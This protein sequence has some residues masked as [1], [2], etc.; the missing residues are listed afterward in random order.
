MTRRSAFLV[1]LAIATVGQSA[2][3]LTY[4]TIGRAG[5]R[6]GAPDL[7]PAVVSF[8]RI[9]LFPGSTIP[10]RLLSKVPSG[11]AISTIFVVNI[12]A[13]SIAVLVVLSV[14]RAYN[15]MR[16]RPNADAPA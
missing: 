3:A 14:V 10:A 6:T 13:W 15:R 9:A 11:L 2:V 16:G 12:A 5:T 8:L 7:Y 1:S 4:F